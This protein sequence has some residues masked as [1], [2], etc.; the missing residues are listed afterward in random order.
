MYKSYHNQYL[1]NAHLTKLAILSMS[2]QTFLKT[3][4]ILI[5]ISVSLGVLAHTLCRSFCKSDFLFFQR[6]A[7]KQSS[8]AFPTL[9]TYFIMQ[10]SKKLSKALPKTMSSTKR[11]VLNYS[12]LSRTIAIDFFT[13]TVPACSLLYVCRLS[14]FQWVS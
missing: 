2:L 4:G 10:S 7:R 11:N 8:D 12:D 1:Q 13:H 14:M 3:T 9:C 6:R 5:S